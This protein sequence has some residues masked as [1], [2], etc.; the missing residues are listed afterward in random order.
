M[1][2]MIAADAAGNLRERYAQLCRRLQGCGPALAPAERDRLCHQVVALAGATEATLADLLKL[3]EQLRQ[4]A[5]RLDATP[6]LPSGP[7][8][9]H[10]GSSTFVEQGWSLLANGEYEAAAERLRR[11]AE[12]APGDVEVEVMLAWALMR[13]MRY[14]ESL[15]LL[16]QVL[17]RDP[18]H[19][20]ARANLGY[21]RFKQGAFGEAIEQ[22]SLVL[23][24]PS[25]RKASLYAN[26]YVGLLY[27]ER[28]LY[29]DAKSYLASALE[30]GPNLIE[31]WWELGR[32]C[33]LEGNAADAS[34]AWRHGAEA[35]R[36]TVWGERCRQA[37]A[38]SGSG[39][40][41]AAG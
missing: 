38:R 21:V 19:A 17:A 24:T 34:R 41:A 14:D 22:L 18:A 4:L 25:D 31:A 27:L 1:T 15:P 23:R 2:G 39:G 29:A 8:I 13:A 3:K 12:L 9:D 28:G 40:G 7:R 37:L 30:L 5:D 26:F 6:A 16:E 32:A 11:A 35:G 10:L 36:F 20:L 33:Y